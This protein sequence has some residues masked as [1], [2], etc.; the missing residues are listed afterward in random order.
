VKARK[1]LPPSSPLANDKEL[2][3]KKKMKKVHQRRKL[4]EENNQFFIMIFSK[5]FEGGLLREI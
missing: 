2:G 5:L 1:K 4:M 3:G